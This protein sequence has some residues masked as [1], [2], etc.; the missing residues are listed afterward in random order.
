MRMDKMTTKFQEA[1]MDAKSLALGLD[2]NM[3]EPLHLLQA[4]I[5]QE[6]GTLRHVLTKASVNVNQLQQQLR[7]RLAQLPKVSG[8]EGEV[9]MSNDLDK[10][11]NLMDKL[12]QQRGDQFLSLIH[13]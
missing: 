7:E 5:E 13:I 12:A 9:H 4:L 11:L 10:I 6:G 8:V 3:I 1:L 2:N